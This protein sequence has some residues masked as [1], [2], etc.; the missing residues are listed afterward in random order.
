[1][2][3]AWR[4]RDL[5]RACSFVGALPAEEGLAS[6]GKGLN[7]SDRNEGTREAFL[8]EAGYRLE[9][10]PST[11]FDTATPFELVTVSYAE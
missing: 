11:K 6:L 7:L 1:V 2:L 8:F 10:T 3:P 4:W 9:K 5:R